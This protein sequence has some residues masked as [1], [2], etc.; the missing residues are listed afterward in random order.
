MDWFYSLA[1]LAIVGCGLM[2]RVGLM[3]L[4]MFC[5]FGCRSRLMCLVGGRYVVTSNCLRFW[6]VVTWVRA[7]L[8]C[9]PG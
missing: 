1:G 8:G 9:D 2:L 4:F 3:L 6:R 5:P 7:K